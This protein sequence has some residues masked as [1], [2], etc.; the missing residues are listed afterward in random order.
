MNTTN[1]SAVEDTE[2]RVATHSNAQ[3]AAV[4]WLVIGMGS[5]A[6]GKERRAVTALKHM[7][8][9]KPYFLTS[10]WEDGTVSELLRRNGFS[11]T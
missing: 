3:V 7:P 4:P 6:Y 11:F 1:A 8:R 5:M 10:Q 2:T 9:I